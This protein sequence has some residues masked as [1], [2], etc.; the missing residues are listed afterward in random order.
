MR[1]RSAPSC[2]LSLS[3]HASLWGVHFFLPVY[4]TCRL[5]SQL[6]VFKVLFPGAMWSSFLCMSCKNWSPQQLHAHRSD[7]FTFSL[8]AEKQCCLFSVGCLNRPSPPE[9]SHMHYWP[10]E[11]HWCAHKH[12]LCH[13]QY[14]SQPSGRTGLMRLSLKLK[15]L[16]HPSSW[17]KYMYPN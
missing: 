4:I 17:G 9:A 1:W 15:H 5:D 2:H 16:H 13:H 6:Q 14:G 7:Q 12:K 8:P 3:S 11:G 10:W